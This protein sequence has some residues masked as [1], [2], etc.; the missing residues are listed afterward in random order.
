MFTLFAIGCKVGDKATGV[1]YT[2]TGPEQWMPAA[3]MSLSPI[4]FTDEY[5]SSSNNFR[6]VRLRGRLAKRRV[7]PTLLERILGLVPDELLD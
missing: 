4:T 7:E 6:P 5:I 2:K 3:V 1:V